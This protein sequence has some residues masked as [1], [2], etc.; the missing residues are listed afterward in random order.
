MK[1]P[2]LGQDAEFD[3]TVERIWAE[4]QRAGNPQNITMTRVRET[5]HARLVKL[6]HG[7]WPRPAKNK[8][9]K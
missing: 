4:L 6:D 3:E 7:Y 2:P 1:A 5:L 9:E 8:R